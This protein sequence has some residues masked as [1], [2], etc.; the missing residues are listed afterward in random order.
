MKKCP[1]EKCSATNPDDA[2]FCRICGRKLDDNRPGLT[3]KPNR[4]FSEPAKIVRGIKFVFIKGGTF[5][6][7]SPEW[8]YER[9]TMETLHKVTLS[10]FYMSKTT[11][12]NEQFCVF[13]NEVGVGRHMNK[14][15]AEQPYYVSPKLEYRNDNW[16]PK[17]GLENHPVVWV[18]HYG[19]K[20]YCEWLGGRLPTEAEWEYACRAGTRTAFNTGKNLTTSQANY[21]GNFPYDGNDCGIYLG[22]TQPVGSYSPNAWGLYDMHGNVGEWCLDTYDTY[23]TSPQTNPVATP[24]VYIDYIRVCRGGGYDSSAAQCRSA[25]RYPWTHYSGLESV[26]FRAVLPVV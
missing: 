10:G 24:N 22:H 21:N 8:E 3:E 20:E 7:G 15:I 12:T 26:G 1:N 6:M 25:Y 2:K 5:M 11:V 18:T 17:S 4:S 14:I 16:H 13:L 9:N 23:P 19:A